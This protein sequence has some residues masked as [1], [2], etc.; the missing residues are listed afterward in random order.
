MTCPKSPEKGGE[1][2]ELGFSN[3][4]LSAILKMEVK[5]HIT[6]R[7]GQELSSK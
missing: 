5:V 2:R 6:A 3:W 4:S 7:R 1:P